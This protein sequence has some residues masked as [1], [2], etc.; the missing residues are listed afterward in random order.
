MESIGTQ[1]KW[2]DESHLKYDHVKGQVLVI[3]FD[4]IDTPESISVA[5]T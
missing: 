2:S 3:D 4:I 1:T 5:E